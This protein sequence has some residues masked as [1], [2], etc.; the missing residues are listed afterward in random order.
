MCIKFYIVVTFVFSELTW[1][2]QSACVNYANHYNVMGVANNSKKRPSHV[3]EI[4]LHIV[5]IIKSLLSHCLL[6]FDFLSDILGKNNHSET[7]LSIY[8]FYLFFSVLV[9]LIVARISSL[10]LL[11]TITRSLILLWG[12]LKGF[13]SL[14]LIAFQ[15]CQLS[16]LKISRIIIPV[17]LPYLYLFLEFSSCNCVEI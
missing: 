17:G 7:R 9:R 3:N 1:R 8:M 11:N 5:D 15:H 13:L 2:D 16:T 6:N 14:G 4:S 10:H 12:I